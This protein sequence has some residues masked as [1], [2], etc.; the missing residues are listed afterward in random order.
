MARF[1]VEEVKVADDPRLLQHVREARLGLYSLFLDKRFD[2]FDWKKLGVSASVGEVGR[3]ALEIMRAAAERR[4]LN[5]SEIGEY[6]KPI[7]DLS[8]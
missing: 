7:R 1:D 2:G 4:G 3:R 6:T 8:I 5:E